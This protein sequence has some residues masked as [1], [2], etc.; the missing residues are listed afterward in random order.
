VTV[1]FTEE[2]KNQSTPEVFMEMMTRMSAVIALNALLKANADRDLALIASHSMV[3]AARDELLRMVT[4]G[5]SSI[6][7]EGIEYVKKI[8]KEIDEARKETAE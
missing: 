3:Q 4:K 1:F 8:R 2:E 6:P 7:Q 5:I